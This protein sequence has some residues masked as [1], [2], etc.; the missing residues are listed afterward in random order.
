M[1]PGGGCTLV[2]LV[3]VTAEELAKAKSLGPS[4]RGTGVLLHA[5]E[6]LGFGLVTDPKRASATQH[7]DFAKAWAEAERAIPAG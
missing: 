7:P 1:M 4:A 6:S 3:G 2:H 5:L